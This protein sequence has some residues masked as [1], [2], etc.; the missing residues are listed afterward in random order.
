MGYSLLINIHKNITFPFSVQELVTA[1]SRSDIQ[2]YYEYLLAGIVLILMYSVLRRVAMTKF[3]TFGI[4]FCLQRGL[5]VQL[6][7]TYG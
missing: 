7:N 6:F 3:V 2:Q 5:Q 1:R 4:R